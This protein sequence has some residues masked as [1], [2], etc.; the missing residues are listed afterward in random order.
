MHLLAKIAELKARFWEAALD[1][2][3]DVVDVVVE[4]DDY[5]TQQSMLV[6]PAM[7]RRLFKPLQAELF[8]IIRQTPART[9]S[10]SFILRNVRRR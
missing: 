10:S 6:S 4:A 7:Y 3:G 8:A 2:L 9:A 5:G 1:D